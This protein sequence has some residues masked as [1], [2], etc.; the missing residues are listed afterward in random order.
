MGILKSIEKMEN[1]AAASAATDQELIELQA[2]RMRLL[3]ESLKIQGFTEDQAV[4]L[5]S[6]VRT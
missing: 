6:G 1:R 4:Q 3:F 2:K 5:V